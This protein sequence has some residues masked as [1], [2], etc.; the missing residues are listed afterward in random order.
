[1]RYFFH[2]L[3]IIILIISGCLSS[4]PESL[5]IGN[6]L[7]KQFVAE[8]PNA[9][10]IATHF[11]AE[12]TN[13]ILENISNACGNPY[14]TAKEFYR[15]TIDDPDS[16]LKV[17]AWVDWE[18]KEI[19]CTVMY[20]IGGNKTISKRGEPIQRCK[21]HAEAR[22]YGEHVY[23]FDSCGHK[24]EKKQYCEYGCELGFCKEKKEEC[25]KLRTSIG[26]F[27]TVLKK[28]KIGPELSKNI[29]DFLIEKVVI[30]ETKDKN[31]TKIICI[32]YKYIGII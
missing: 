29:I 30:T 9:K 26:V 22:C 7:V 27:I 2:F 20:G 18:K 24:E 28:M 3:I 10:L 6:P 21:S 13:Q 17:V 32:Y 1:M 12:Q 4:S 11:T 14:I 31:N 19:E 5:A 25:D 16:G 23:W 15:I 8:Y